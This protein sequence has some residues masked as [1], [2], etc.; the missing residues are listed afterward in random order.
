MIDGDL[1]RRQHEA[2]VGGEIELD[3]RPAAATRRDRAEIADLAL[4]GDRAAR[5]LIDIEILLV[6]RDFD[7]GAIVDPL[8]DFAE[9]ALEEG[10]VEVLCVGE[11]EVEIFREAVG[12]EPAFLET[13]AALEHPAAADV[14]MGVD[15]GQHPAEDIVLLDDVRE[16]R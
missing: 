12:L 4:A 3:A 2:L 7:A 11:R 15:A 8:P 10:L 6:G 5:I 9:D 1:D 13:G 16:Q 14:G